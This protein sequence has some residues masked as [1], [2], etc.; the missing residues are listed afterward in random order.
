M[1]VTLTYQLVFFFL[2]FSLRVWI[3]RHLVTIFRFAKFRS[4]Y[5]QDGLSFYDTFLWAFHFIL[6]RSFRNAL[7]GNK[8][9][10]LE[11]WRHFQAKNRWNKEER[12]TRKIVC[13][14][15]FNLC[16]KFELYRMKDPN[17]CRA[18]RA[19]CSFEPHNFPIL[20]ETFR[21]PQNSSSDLILLK[22]C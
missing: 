2:A 19:A 7:F 21:S 20:S 1:S 16:S 11:L 4:L 10:P 5:F 14:Q 15:K 22:V 18:Q 9:R 8:N 3:F 17:V 12:K 13:N 6:T